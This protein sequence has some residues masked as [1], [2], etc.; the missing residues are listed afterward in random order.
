MDRFHVSQWN[1]RAEGNA[2]IVLA[3]QGNDPL[4]K[5]G[6]LL[7]LKK[8]DGGEIAS[9]DPVAFQKDI[10]GPLLGPDYL[11]PLRRVAVTPAF[12]QD[13][14]HAI[15]PHRPHHRHHRG[16]DHRARFGL[17]TQDLTYRSILTCELKPKWGFKPTSKQ[18]V[19]EHARIKSTICRFCMHHFLKHKTLSDYCPLDI[20]SL[21]R[22]RM[23]RALR[24]IQ[25]DDHNDKFKV[26]HNQSSVSP[27][28]AALEILS[29]DACLLP[30]LA[31]LQTRLD[32]LD[33]EGIWP[34]YKRCPVDDI[35]D[36]QT[37]QSVV[38]R[39][40]T[41]EVRDDPVQRILEYVLSMTFK[42]CSILMSLYAYDPDLPFVELD[43][44]RYAYAIKVIDTDM[45]KVSKIPLWYGLDQRI[46]QNALQYA[47][48]RECDAEKKYN[49]VA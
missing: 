14:A 17:L 8:D 25:Q 33:V 12:L 43:G 1:Y 6:T 23:T 28:Q 21:D 27:A 31:E 38:E 3:Y 45:K 47:L 46:V 44:T 2:N 15:A 19:P 36:T 42:D 24:A 10:I 5:L 41:A 9:H 40:L 30:R 48:R 7:R 18:I 29:H 32:T 34:L 4:Y 39:F 20:Y 37:W 22:C 11:I 16:I 13:M 26:L 49:V 35:H